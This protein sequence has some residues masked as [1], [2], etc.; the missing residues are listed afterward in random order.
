MPLAERQFPGALG[1]KGDTSMNIYAPS[2][3]VEHLFESLKEVVVDESTLEPIIYDIRF[4]RTG[5][6][7]TDDARKKMSDAAKKRRHTEETKRKM[8]E[9]RKGKKY[10]EEEKAIAYASRIGRKQ[11]KET[12]EKRSKSLKGC[13]NFKHKSHSEETKKKMS[14]V[15]K[16]WWEEKDQ[17]SP[18]VPPL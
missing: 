11:S 6:R 10:S 8:S 5:I 14:E 15:R 17:S 9:K 18:S 3:N 2:K 12:C 4:D 7:H 16:K 1:L 13:Q